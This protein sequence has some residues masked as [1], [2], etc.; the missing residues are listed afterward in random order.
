MPLASTTVMTESREYI[1]PI[2]SST[3]KVWTTGAGSAN[4]VVSM[5]TPSEPKQNA[6][7]SEGVIFSLANQCQ[8]HGYDANHLTKFFDPFVKS[9]ERLHK[10]S[11]NG[12]TNTSVH[13]LDDLLIYGLRKD[14]LIYTDFSEFVLDDC[15]FHAMCLVIQDTI[16]QSGLAAAEEAYGRTKIND[17]VRQHDSCPYKIEVSGI[18]L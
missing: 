9:L 6:Q 16:E 8:K 3:K 12:A 17:S 11:A 4:P 15:K 5:M 13:D 1:S 10:I 7:L 18:Y 2:V 14:L